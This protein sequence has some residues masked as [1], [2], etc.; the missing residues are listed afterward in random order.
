VLTPPEREKL[1]KVAAVLG[2]RPK[3]ALAVGGIHAEVDR[4]ALQEV[5][6]R[7]AVLTAS[8]LDALG[9]G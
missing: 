6:L 9:A 1:L 5:Q 2:K 7:R 8:G 3:L 4:V